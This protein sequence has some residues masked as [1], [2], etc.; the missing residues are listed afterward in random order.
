MVK[1]ILAELCSMY[2]KPELYGLSDMQRMM[3][4]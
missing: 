4:H 1:P 2:S 3:V